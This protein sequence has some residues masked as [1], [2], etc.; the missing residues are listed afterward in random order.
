MR[1]LRL[2][3][4]LLLSLIA[5]SVCSAQNNR[6]NY[7]NQQ[8]FLSGANL[9]WMHYASDIGPGTT[10]PTA[11]AD[12]FLIWH[13]SGGNA[14]RWWL[15]TNGTVSPAFNDSG[16]VVA[17]GAG[18][19]EDLKAVLDLAW[20]REIGVIPCLWSFGMLDKTLS[21]SV[22]NR[23]ILLLTD[24]VYTRRYINSCLIPMVQTLKGHPAIVAWEIFNEPEGMSTEMG[25]TMTQH[26]PMAAIQRF[27]NL[28]SGAI[29]RVDSTA[30]VTNGA[31]TFA[32]LTD[33]STTELAKGAV[34]AI[35]LS[36]ADKLRA[37]AELAKKYQMDITPEEIV[38]HFDAMSKT[39]NFNYYSDSRLIAAGGDPDGILDFYSV[40][41]YVNNGTLMSPFTNQASKWSL[42]KPIVVAEFAMS[43]AQ[44]VPKEYLYRTLYQNGYAGA[45]A[46]SWTDVNLS[47]HADVLAGMLSMWNTYRSDV[48][49][50]G[51]GNHW[52]TVMITSPP[53][54]SLFADTASVTIVASASDTLGSIVRVEFFVS[55][56]VKIGEATSPP[57]AMT[58][59]NILPNTY[60][61]TAVATN[62]QGNKRTSNKVRITVGI[63]PMTKLEAES[64]AIW[65]GPG[66]SRGTDAAASGGAY[67]DVKSNDSL[68][69][70]TWRVTNVQPAGSYQIAFGAK[71][72]YASPK[73]QHIKVNGV[74]AGDLEFASASSSA[75][76]E[77]SMS[78][79]L[80]EG[81]NTIQM[82]MYWG[83]MYVDY[84]AVPTKVLVSVP[85]GTSTMPLAWVLEQNYPNPFNPTTSIRYS[86][87]VDSRQS[88]VAAKVRLA[89]YDLLGREVTVLVDERRQPGVY[90]ATWN[91]AGMASGVYFY[92]LTTNDYTLCRS[93]V[94]LK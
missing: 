47:T 48:D 74:R 87:G 60:T 46:W 82:Q 52:P 26:V 51:T 92:R 73:A 91:A 2:S 29:H 72:A 45:L 27:I 77:K 75:W 55:D 12:T 56:S 65:S 22:L 64:G 30:R 41:Y 6:V 15:H 61:I 3:G 43:E 17:P 71:L 50:L 88:I 79:D 21:A 19:I 35:Q 37:A 8:L 83:W 18:T 36:Q 84:L 28:C 62:D 1:S 32:S 69:T 38:S 42:D 5:L 34:E 14:A 9:A 85:E 23:N 4:S 10:D 67:V 76:F 89:V 31:V 68:T 70:L 13:E 40:H 63:P 59:R 39:A 81:L 11:F 49:V 53:N 16:F 44:T 57:Y 93:M 78:V 80:I 90:T 94:L 20:E 24:T 66:M 25:W 86:V 7:N 33:V 54:D 58:W